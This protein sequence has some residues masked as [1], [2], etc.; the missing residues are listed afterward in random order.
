MAFSRWG[1]VTNSLPG[2]K[3]SQLLGNISNVYQNHIA[4]TPGNW[5]KAIEMALL[6]RHVVPAQ[7]VLW[8]KNGLEL[9]TLE[10]VC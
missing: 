2:R 7:Q 10:G 4:P 5:A 6:P 1:H 8:R 9:F 3:E